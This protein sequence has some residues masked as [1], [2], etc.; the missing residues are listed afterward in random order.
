MGLASLLCCASALSASGLPV[1]GIVLEAAGWVTA[2]P[3]DWA[4]PPLPLC[5][6]T[7]LRLAFMHLLPPTCSAAGV[8]AH[9]KAKDGFLYPLP[10]ALC[11]LDSVR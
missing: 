8:R 5:P 10:S 2:W 9:V 4:W 1:A 11:F 7:W 3:H 6:I